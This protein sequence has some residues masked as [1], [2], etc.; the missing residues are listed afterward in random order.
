[1]THFPKLLFLFRLE[2]FFLEVRS[3]TNLT[4]HHTTRLVKVTQ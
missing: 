1:M 2:Q 3:H 4:I